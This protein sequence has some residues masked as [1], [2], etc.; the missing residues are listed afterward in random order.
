VERGEVSLPIYTS[1]FFD[2]QCVYERLPALRAYIS[3]I[4]VSVPNQ[5]TGSLSHM[6][7]ALHALSRLPITHL[8]KFMTTLISLLQAI[9]NLNTSFQSCIPHRGPHL[10]FSERQQ[11]HVNIYPLTLAVLAT[12]QCS[13]IYTVRPGGRYIL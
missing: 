6:Y 3:Y 4:T 13:R 5:P 2:A 11:L 12:G 7:P 8:L 10:T 9:R 1:S